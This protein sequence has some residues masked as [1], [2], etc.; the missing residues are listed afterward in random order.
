MSCVLLVDDDPAVRGLLRLFLEE[1]GYSVLEAKEG[2]EALQFLD[3]A[4]VVVTDMVMPDKE[5]IEVIRICRRLRPKLPVIAISG[6]AFGESYLAIATHLGVG[7]ALQ[8]PI[9]RET[10]L[11]SVRRALPAVA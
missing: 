7:Q 4:D 2:S 5:G 6:A 11:N 10:L 9:S 3:I 8:K 1:A